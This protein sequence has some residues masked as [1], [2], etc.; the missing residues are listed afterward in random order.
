MPADRE[1]ATVRILDVPL[2]ADKPYDYYVPAELSGAVQPGCLVNVPFGRGNR[3]VSAVVTSLSD[4]CDYDGV[5]PI[6]SVSASGVVLSEDMLAVCRFLC[7]Y[8]LCTFGEAARCTVPQAAF[9][10]LREYY[11]VSENTD[12]EKVD[13][14]SEK[15]IFF[16]NFISARGKVSS[17]RLKNEFGSEAASLAASLVRLGL[18]NREIEHKDASGGVYRVNA[19][20]TEK[21]R[22]LLSD[23]EQFNRMRS[24][25]QAQILAILGKENAMMSASDIFER[26]GKNGRVQLN[27]LEK[28]GLVEIE[29]QQVY[30]GVYTGNNAGCAPEP[31]SPMQ[32]QA[33]SQIEEQYSSGEPRAALLHGVTGS[34]KTRVI[35]AMIDRVAADGR[36][37]IVLVPE[38]ALTPQ[39]V[40]IFC[41]CYGER[42]AVIHSSLSKGERL[43]AWNRIRQGKADIVIGTRSAVFAPLKNIGMIVIDEEQ[44]HTYK[45]DTDPKYS[46]H[47]VARY[48]CGK[49]NALMLL[50]SATPSLNS[51]YKA[52]KGTYKLVEMT[53]RFGN[54]NLPD[55]II[56]D[57]RA[58]LDSGNTSPL[59]SVLAEKLRET[60]NDSLQSVVLLNRRG[61]NSAVYCRVCGE[62]VKC[63]NCSV[64]LTYHT[65]VPL[66]E[67]DSPEAYIKQRQA[68]GI[69]ACHYCGYRSPVPSN[70]PSCKAEHFR[71]AGCGTQQA[72]EAIEKA[73]PGARVIRM[74]MDTTGTKS[75]HEKLLGAFRRGEA[76]ILLGTQMVAKGHDFPKVTLVG[77]INADSS[78]YLDDFR[79]NER[80][81]SM[82]T[83]VIGRAG[84]SKDAGV[85]VVQTCNP[86][87]QVIRLA[88][89]QNY[90]AFYSQEIKLR[91]AFT[92]PPFCDIALITLSGRNEALL[93]ASSKALSERLKALLNGDYSDVEAVVFGPFEAPVYK[94]QNTCRMRTV[95]KCRLNKRSRALIHTLLC[96]FGAAS[97]SD[98]ISISADLNPSK[99]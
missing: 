56:S 66:G 13:K 7:G 72:Q 2:Y 79:A 6:S 81:F 75:S 96:E 47:D 74:D 33:Y 11:S 90:K 27:S 93:A 42:V 76:D 84:R 65:R 59:G 53:E 43:D 38:I 48:R 14:L 73:V 36:G 89:S 64:S 46:A 37:V 55:V 69:L 82:L 41:G 58:E 87:N 61:Y 30:R 60:R 80:T 32:T 39:T 1:Y 40:S 23:P 62:A 49:H 94:V 92:F 8:T 18:I 28:K 99:L 91:Q 88:A 15:S 9:S 20:I 12:T 25:M 70:C 10:K 19:S 95:L 44:E 97:R 45:S 52:E 83:Q 24:P 51:Y 85:A 17:D 34:G 29:Q 68:R 50:S 3:K 21:G 35:Q 4:S 57:M 26:L 98:Q 22:E 86:D 71:F 31:M 78:L 77:V 5:K 63:P 67:T 16:Y 54:A